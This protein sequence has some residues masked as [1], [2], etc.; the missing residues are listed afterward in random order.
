M[1]RPTTPLTSR[2]AKSGSPNCDWSHSGVTSPGNAL[3]RTRDEHKR[4]PDGTTLHVSHFAGSRI[5]VSCEVLTYLTSWRCLSERRREASHC[6]RY[7]EA[8]ADAGPHG[9]HGRLYPQGKP[10]CPA[11][12]AEDLSTAVESIHKRTTVLRIITQGLTWMKWL[13][14]CCQ[15]PTGPWRVEKGASLASRARPLPL[16]RLRKGSPSLSSVCFYSLR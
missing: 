9:P 16:Q 1:A 10:V 4:M 8:A 6:R 2:T 11:A 3:T 14:C 15:R 7:E 5:M 12:A 13:N